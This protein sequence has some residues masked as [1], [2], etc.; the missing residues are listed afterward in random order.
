MNSF[1]FDKDNIK[2][3]FYESYK[4][5]LQTVRFTTT[6]TVYLNII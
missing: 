6:Q 2:S 3:R 1:D 4:E 5:L